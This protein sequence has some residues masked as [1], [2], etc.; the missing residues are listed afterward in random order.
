MKAVVFQSPSHVHLLD[1]PEPQPGGTG[2]SLITVIACGLCGSDQRT[3]TDPPKMPCK[4]DTVLG[5]EIVGRI[6]TP[7]AGSRFT[8]GDVVVVVPNYPC[9]DCHSCRRGLINLCDHFNHIGAI[10]DGGLTERLWVPDEFLHPVPPGLDP[11]IAVLAEP[12]ACVLNGTTRARWVSGEAAVV[13]GAG[14]IGQLFTVVAKLSGVAPLI[15]TEPIPARAQLARELGADHVIDPSQNDALERIAQLAGGHG[16][17]TVIDSVGTLLRSALTLVAKG[18]EVF[19]FGVDHAAEITIA[20]TT[21]VDKEVS[22]HGI[23]IAKG[24]FPLAMSLLSAHQELFGK[25][26]TDRYPIDEWER[27]KHTLVNTSAAGKIL[28]TNDET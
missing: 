25:I 22:I 2:E 16:V 20:P 4:P 3:M 13:L 14:P 15:V 7:A 1:R 11:H 9:R 18:G 6:T 5:H 8:A 28:V 21:I 19:V 27:A 24:T 26:V 23:Y 12:L 10:T 17:P